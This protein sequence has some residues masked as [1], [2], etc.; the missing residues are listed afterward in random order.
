MFWGFKESERG[1][2]V[3]TWQKV[4]S[5]VY[6]TIEYITHTSENVCII[7]KICGAKHFRCKFTKNK[8][9]FRVIDHM[10]GN[11]QKGHL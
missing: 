7:Q 8:C 9:V 10:H 6:N 1:G 2:R 5:Y 4:Y 11:V 3:K